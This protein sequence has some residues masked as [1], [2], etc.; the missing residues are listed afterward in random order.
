VALCNG[1]LILFVYQSPERST[2][3]GTSLLGRI[4]GCSDLFDTTCM[5]NIKLL[6]LVYCSVFT[7]SPRSIRFSLT[8]KTPPRLCF[9]FPSWDWNQR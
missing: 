4:L 5:Q 2:D 6:P 1:D 8:L 3:G 7:L 9:L